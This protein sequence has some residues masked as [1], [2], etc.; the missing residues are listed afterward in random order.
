MGYCEH[1]KKILQPLQI[2]ELD[3]GIGAAE[4][5]TE[6][7]AMDSIEAVLSDTLRNMLPATADENGIEFWRKLFPFLP[8]SGSLEDGRASLVTM[9]NIGQC[10]CSDQG[11]NFVLGACGL[12]AN[13]SVTSTKEL[14]KVTI[15][16]EELSGSELQRVKDC[17]EAI[18]PCHLEITYA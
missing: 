6:G 17:V 11:L 1:L 5:E 16:D 10:E 4:L 18:L 12:P 8:D 9:L 15:L 14:L 2:Y 7:A 13:V 3:T